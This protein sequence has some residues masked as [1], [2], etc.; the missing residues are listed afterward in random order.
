MPKSSKSVVVI[1]LYRSHGFPGLD[2]RAP[3]GSRVSGSRTPGRFFRRFVSVTTAHYRIICVVFNII[4]IIIIVAPTRAD[5][6]KERE[7]PEDRRSVSETDERERYT[8]P[9]KTDPDTKRRP[10]SDFKTFKRMPTKKKKNTAAYYLN[11]FRTLSGR[12]LPSWR[13]RIDS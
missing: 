9:E 1:F 11:I 13:S 2:A 8:V 5:N 3:H 10:S 12:N 7:E 4:I 6:K